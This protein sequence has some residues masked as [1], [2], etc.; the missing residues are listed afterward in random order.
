M[1]PPLM[2]VAEK[3]FATRSV[4]TAGAG[5]AAAECD[6][7]II[8]TATNAAGI[9]DALAKEKGRIDLFMA[10]TPLRQTLLIRC[11]ILT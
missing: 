2:P 5:C 1:T 11:P 7:A 4:S 10:G 8:M 9:N 6:D 3:I